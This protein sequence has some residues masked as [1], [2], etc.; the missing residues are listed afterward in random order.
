MTGSTLPSPCTIG[1][2][3]AR[4]GATIT[5]K[6]RSPDAN[7]RSTPNLRP[8]VSADGLNRSCGRVSQPGKTS[9]ACVPRRSPTAAARSSAPTAVA[10][11]ARMMPPDST[12][13]SASAQIRNG[14]AAAGAI[15]STGAEVTPTRDSASTTTGSAVN[16]SRRP[17]SVTF[18]RPPPLRH[19]GRRRAQAARQRDR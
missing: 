8:T 3:T 9:T 19:A 7:R 13:S 18:E 11:T 1:C 10:V 5:R 17:L 4:I 16:T 15:T 14:R 6:S 2:S 12:R